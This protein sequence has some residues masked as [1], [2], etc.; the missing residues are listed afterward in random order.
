MESKGNAYTV[1]G[2]KFHGASRRDGILSY[3][4]IATES[5]WMRYSVDLHWLPSG[6]GDLTTK[7]FD[8]FQGFQSSP[9][10]PVVSTATG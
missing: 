4:R 6:L 5:L 8:K 3:I 1:R 2:V 10:A 9:M 7:V